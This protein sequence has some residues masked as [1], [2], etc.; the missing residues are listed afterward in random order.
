MQN[1]YDRTYLLDHGWTEQ[2]IDRYVPFL[3]GLSNMQL[4]ELHTLCNVRMFK[5]EEAVD[6]EQAVYVLL[7]P[8][9]TPKELLFTGLKELLEI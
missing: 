5:L 1:L 8:H 9:D 2:E 7:N 4:R 3:A 6:R